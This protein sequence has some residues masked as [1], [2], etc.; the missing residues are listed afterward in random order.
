MNCNECQEI[1]SDYID[2]MLEMGEQATIERHLA[3]CEPC[4][5]VR[6]D[7]L[8][9]IHFSR[10][11]PLHTPS[12]AVWARIQSSV[13]DEQPAGFL[14]RIK[15]W[16]GRLESRHLN[17]SLPQLAAS[18]VALAVVVSVGVMFAKHGDTDTSTMQM[19]EAVPP[20]V[21]KVNPL[22]SPERQ[23]VEERISYLE[24]NIQQRK[25]NWDPE[26]RQA[27]EKNM[28]YVEQSLLECQ[29]HLSGNPN[30]QVSRELMLNAYREKIRLLEGFER[31]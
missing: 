7:L 22:S 8:Q 12:S 23:N 28:L 24:A 15:A 19:A 30:D 16:I 29:Q 31:F 3:D 11:L 10:Q 21:L 6:D 2:G 26:L 18:A 1:I 20:S 13:A 25:A 14:P 27:F 5:M 4:R 17:L 9:V